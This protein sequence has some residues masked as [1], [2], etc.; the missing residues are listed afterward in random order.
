MA[1]IIGCS[2]AFAVFIRKTINSKKASYNA[3]GYIKHS[4]DEIKLKSLTGPSTRPNR[5]NETFWNDGH[6]SQEELAKNDGIMVTTTFRQ[7]S[8]GRPITRDRI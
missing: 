4:T 1:I 5:N 7:D 2:P 6:S 8:E 3:Q